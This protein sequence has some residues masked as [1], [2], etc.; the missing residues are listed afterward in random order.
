MANHRVGENTSDDRQYSCKKVGN[1]NM[2]NKKKRKS[3][4]VADCKKS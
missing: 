3:T 4:E 2:K 1:K